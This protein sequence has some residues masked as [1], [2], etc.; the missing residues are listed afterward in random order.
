MRD[1]LQPEKIMGS[2]GNSC[3]ED[4]SILQS[5]DRQL[6]GINLASEILEKKLGINKELIRDALFEIF[7]DLQIQGS[8]YHYQTENDLPQFKVAVKKGML[9]MLKS[10]L[11]AL[12]QTENTHCDLD[13]ALDQL[14]HWYMD[15]YLPSNYISE[16]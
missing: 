11:G 3:D 15:E 7:V 9:P 4:Y 8:R 14:F 2:D 16:T 5:T 1:D 10:K 12:L 6:K 13:I